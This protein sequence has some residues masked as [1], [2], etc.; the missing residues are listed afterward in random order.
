MLELEAELDGIA[1]ALTTIDRDRTRE[2]TIE[3]R[4]QIRPQLGEWSRLAESRLREGF[5]LTV[6][7][8]AGGEHAIDSDAQRE[9]VRAFVRLPASKQLRRHVAARAGNFER[10]AL[11]ETSQARDAQVDELQPTVRFQQDVL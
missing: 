2:R 6:G 4:R 7:I 9:D 11:I 8:R 5:H 1:E 10:L 3:P